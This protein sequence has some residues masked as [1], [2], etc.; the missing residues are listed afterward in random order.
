MPRSQVHHGCGALAGFAGRSLVLEDDA[1]QLSTQPVGQP[2]VFDDG[3][4]EA[5]AAQHGVVVGV[6]GSAH[7]L[8]DHQV[9][10]TL[11]HHHRQHFVQAARKKSEE[12]T[13]HW[14]EFWPAAQIDAFKNKNKLRSTQTSVFIL[15]TP[16]KDKFT[17]ESNYVFTIS[18]FRRISLEK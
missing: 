16:A 6:D 7:P 3:H 5:L 2:R 18:F 1:E 15:H 12:N 14:S 8:D 10:L 11:P 9:G 17:F 4:L 13:G